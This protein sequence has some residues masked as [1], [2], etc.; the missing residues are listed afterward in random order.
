MSLTLVTVEIGQIL[1]ELV[2]VAHQDLHYGT[3][4]V[5]VGNKHLHVTYLA[6]TFATTKAAFIPTGTTTYL[7]ASEGICSPCTATITK[8]GNTLYNTHN[9]GMTV[10]MTGVQA[11][12]NLTAYKETL[13][14]VI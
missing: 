1:E 2:S 3:S 9:K 4:L 14:R 7:T 5:G 6:H 13:N 12:Y 11:L 10:S 8:C